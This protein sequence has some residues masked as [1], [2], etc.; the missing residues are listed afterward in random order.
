MFYWVGKIVGEAI[1]KY[2]KEELNASL[3]MHITDYI[4]M[5][6]EDIV[7]EVL[8]QKLTEQKEVVLEKISTML[9]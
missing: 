8:T 9:S 5:E 6:F 3:Q 2:E 4:T 1:R 7:T